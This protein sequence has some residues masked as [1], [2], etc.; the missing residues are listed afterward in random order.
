MQFL[1]ILL[2]IIGFLAVAGQLLRALLLALGTGVESFLAREV[3]EVNARR[4]D[5]TALQESETR[6][7]VARRAR[8]GA[9]ARLALWTA[10]LAVPPFTQFTAIVYACYSPL[11][12]LNRLRRA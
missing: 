3:T 10:L 6:H 8:L 2:A 12:L 7:R 11:W 4:G 1:I 5:L 9:V